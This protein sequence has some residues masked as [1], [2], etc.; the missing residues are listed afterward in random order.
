MQCQMIVNVIVHL[1]E[2]MKYAWIKKK[3]KTKK[4]K[5]NKKE[6]IKKK[7]EKEK[8]RKTINY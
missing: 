6:K 7:K 8:K 3:T 2:S 1:E 5:Q 4:Q